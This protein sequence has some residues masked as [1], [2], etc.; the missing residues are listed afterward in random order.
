V[1][2]YLK[3]LEA[4]QRPNRLEFLA[5]HPEIARELDACLD[6]LAFVHAAVSGFRK[7]LTSPHGE[8][9][10]LRQKTLGDYQL[11]REIGRGGMGIVYEALQLSLGR[12]LALKV[13]PF[14]AAL[15]SRRSQRFKNEALAA[16]Q[17]QHRHI[18][19]VYA[20]GCEQGVHYYTMQLIE[21]QSLAA[22]IQ[23]ARI[24]N[25]ENTGVW[26]QRSRNARVF[27]RAVA[28]LAVQ[29]AEALE[30][31]HQM[32][33][34]HRDIKPANLLLDQCDNVWITDFGLARFRDD[35]GF[36]ETGTILGTLR[37]MSPEQTRAQRVV[38]HRTDIYS[39]GVSLYELLTVEPAFP[40][41]DPTT[42]LRQIGEED[43]RPPRLLERTIPVDLETIILKAMAKKPEDRYATAQEL[44]DDMVNFLEN[45]PI[46]AR[47]PTL[48][49]QTSKWARR[50]QTVTVSAVV[51][52]VLL[53][54]GSF[55]TA[56]LLARKQADLNEAYRQEQK[57]RDRFEKSF[58]A[59]RAVVDF[60]ANLGEEEILA[61]PELIDL[62]RKILNKTLEYYRG[63]IKERQDDPS[64][65]AELADAEARGSAILQEM[66]ALEVFSRVMFMTL[67]LKHPAVGEDLQLSEEQRQKIVPLHPP[68]PGMPPP[69][70][71][72][73]R[74]TPEQRRKILEGMTRWHETGLAG[75]L[76]VQQ[77][78]RLRELALQARG[79][80]AFNDPEVARTLD[81][82]EKQVQAIR[83][84]QEEAGHLFFRRQLTG[85]PLPP[86]TPEQFW[87]RANQQLSMQLTGRQK[88][89][90]EKMTGE[91]LRRPIRWAVLGG[92]PAPA[93]GP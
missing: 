56:L 58:Q 49:E 13:L 14:A 8:E 75:A 6:G 50:H 79:P 24:G 43:P 18:V 87:E 40:A 36:T 91:R 23:Q 71:P 84:I 26:A 25:G 21:G 92:Q 85:S 82:T 67:L 47:R 59:A 80:F 42:L 63:F 51:L 83:T 34:V 81:L 93:I 60:F 53:G 77:R 16:A 17:L 90:W 19:P 61:R 22:V 55:V 11:L 88:A 62:R 65:Q 72:A 38:D 86:E 31:A 70:R 35:A 69:R 2:E 28:R 45:R 20:V 57:Q 4:G 46:R 33:V 89:S 41:T 68:L 12:R 54:V 78:K 9:D 1:Q 15:D 32:G 30:Y 27:F 29:A 10:P 74:L 48:W 5:R 76:T 39:L 44:A 66:A 7:V 52:L 73:S 3:T 37:Y 64:I